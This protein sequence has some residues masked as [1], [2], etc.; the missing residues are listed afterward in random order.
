[1]ELG[2]YRFAASKIPRYPFHVLQTL[3][4]RTGF[5][6]VTA[7]L[8]LSYRVFH[9]GAWIISVRCVKDTMVSFST[10]RK[11]LLI[12]YEESW[13]SKESLARFFG[14]SLVDPLF[15]VHASNFCARISIWSLPSSEESAALFFPL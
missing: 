1:M 12:G 15:L 13:L 9:I 7:S 5:P 8:K 4:Y 3:K 11:Q 6:I 2:L 14:E 10:C